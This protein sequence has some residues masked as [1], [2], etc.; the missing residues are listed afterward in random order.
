MMT[1]LNIRFRFFATFL[2]FVL[3]LIPITDPLVVP[4]LWGVAP[5]VHVTISA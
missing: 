5:V 1:L 4:M 2:S 3:T